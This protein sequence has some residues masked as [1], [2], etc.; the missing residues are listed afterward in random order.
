MDLAPILEL[1][2]EAVVA[3]AR[4]LGHEPDP[5]ATL[6][7]DRM[8]MQEGQI[9]LAQGHQ[10][11]VRAEVGLEHDQLAVAEDVE[12]QLALLG[13][14]SCRALDPDLVA[15]VGGGL[16]L[17]ERETLV[18]GVSVNCKVGSQGLGTAVVG[19]VGEEPPVRPRVGERSKG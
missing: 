6:T 5:V 4:E 7:L 9:T 10:V 13:G 17:L 14:R 2:E 16:G 15:V 12:R 19:E 1:Q 3:L 8:D 11:A 18:V